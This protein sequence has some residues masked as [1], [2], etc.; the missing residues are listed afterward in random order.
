MYGYGVNFFPLDLLFMDMKTEVDAMLE[1]Y[2]Q[3]TPPPPVQFF[4]LANKPT[5]GNMHFI[6]KTFQGAFEVTSTPFASQIFAG[7]WLTFC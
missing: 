7:K 6:Q 2:G 1:K 5:A 4:T 3:D